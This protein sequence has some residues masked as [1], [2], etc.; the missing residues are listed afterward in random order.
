[1][2]RLILANQK[3][4]LGIW[5][6]IPRTYQ[7]LIYLFESSQA[8]H[9]ERMSHWVLAHER[10]TVGGDAEA[11]EWEHEWEHEWDIKY[12]VVGWEYYGFVNGA[13]CLQ[14]LV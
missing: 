12:E 13:E 6:S 8:R 7:L 9:P 11:S 3:E 1:M 14:M 2:R 10:I 5:I 4:N